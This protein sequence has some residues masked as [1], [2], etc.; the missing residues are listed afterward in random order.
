MSLEQLPVSS[1]APRKNP[2]SRAFLMTFAMALMACDKPSTPV[3]APEAPAPK[4]PSAL[5]ADTLV[6]TTVE[7]R[8]ALVQEVLQKTLGETGWDF[9]TRGFT[10]THQDLKN[11]VVTELE[12]WFGPLRGINI[13]TAKQ[14]G[15]K[16]LTH[17]MSDYQGD[18][19][20]DFSDRTTSWLVKKDDMSPP[21]TRFVSDRF[22]DPGVQDDYATALRTALRVLD[23]EKELKQK[24]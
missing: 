20:P 22:I 24:K 9:Y 5:L 6:G 17:T 13:V 15:G 3:A 23:E 1:S 4:A 18:G 12:T 19:I 16:T 21:V 10:Y 8:Q 11:G 2:L 7:K 14:E